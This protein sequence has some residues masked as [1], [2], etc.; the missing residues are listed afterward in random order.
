MKE[1]IKNMRLWTTMSKTVY[2]DTI[3]KNGIYTCDTYKCNMLINDTE[4]KNFENAYN[5]L[6]DYMNYKIGKP[7]NANTK[8][9]V[10]AWYKLRGKKSRP[11]LRWT[12]F[13]D[14]RE[15]MVLIECEIED[16]KV[17]L[18]DEVKW[19]VSA[20]NNFPFLISDEEYDWY[21]YNNTLSNED[22]KLFKHNTW[23][24][25]FDISESEYIQATFWELRK[26]NIIKI[27]EFNN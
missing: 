16:N 1:C 3:I 9:P 15:P 19:T 5:W 23:L 4:D 27:W 22:L 21:Y 6:A 18:S 12:E 17:V 13:K 2:K 10:W 26:E 8:Y 11:D 14:Y 20:L 7:N 24:R 25:V